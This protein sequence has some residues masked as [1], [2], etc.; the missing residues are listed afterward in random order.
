MLSKY[1]CI[2]SMPF[3]FAPNE[4]SIVP[5]SFKCVA[6]WTQ[7][8]NR[9]A[10]DVIMLWMRYNTFILMS[11]V[12]AAFQVIYVLVLLHFATL[13]LVSGLAI[14]GS[15]KV[16]SKPAVHKI[17]RVHMNNCLFLFRRNK[18]N[19]RLLSSW[20]P[21][22]KSRYL[23]FQSLFSCNC[24]S[25]RSTCCLTTKPTGTWL[26]WCAVLLICFLNE[27]TLT[28]LSPVAV[29]NGPDNLQPGNCGLKLMICWFCGLRP[30]SLQSSRGLEQRFSK[31]IVR[32][33]RSPLEK[34]RRPQAI[35]FFSFLI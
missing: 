15:F 24:R 2:K 16:G 18:T 11:H 8:G 21:V 23:R 1:Y 10:H 30:K 22:Q 4:P 9:S 6:N 12:V 5:R 19:C 32:S 17:S 35:S 20:W 13:C 25:L 7:V 26:K 28:G 33:P 34:P 14:Y 27:F 29:A 31:C 3:C